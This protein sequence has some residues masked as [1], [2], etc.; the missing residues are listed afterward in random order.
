MEEQNELARLWRKATLLEDGTVLLGKQHQICCDGFSSESTTGVIT[1]FHID[2][3]HGLES[4]L[5]NLD[6]VVVSKETRGL[7][8]ALKGNY[9]SYRANLIAREPGDPFPVTGGRLTLWPCKHVL[10][11]S[12]VLFEDE[13]GDRMVYTGDFNYPT[14]RPIEAD[15]LV[16]D[17]TYGSP[18]YTHGSRQEDAESQLVKLVE[19]RLSEKRPV[20]ICA[21]SGRAQEIMC[22]LREK[23]VQAPFLALEKNYSLAREYERLGKRMGEIHQ[24]RLTIDR[25]IRP[26]DSG[27]GETKKVLS[28]GPFV[29]FFGIHS[30]PQRTRGTLQIEVTRYFHWNDPNNVMI[31][32][33]A[34]RVVLPLSDHAD[35]NGIMSYIQ[36][37]SPK[38]VIPR[39]G[40]QTALAREVRKRFN[41][42]CLEDT[43]P[44][45]A[46][47]QLN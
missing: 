36:R 9:L 29:A 6:Q 32:Y 20:Y 2:H 5:H 4:C 25:M 1:H 12:Q 45:P 27:Q 3:I 7:L 10:G 17:A 37:S 33:D 34:D 23:K 21:S 14:T 15:L 47:A 42:E 46:W 22:L 16:L 43:Q 30:Q 40:D 24:I 11:A 35:F 18:A 44:L 39:G 19:N 41:I 31:Q 38:L 28:S 8:V 26:V 13:E